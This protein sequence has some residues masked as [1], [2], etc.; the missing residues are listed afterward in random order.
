MINVMNKE[1]V[2]EFLT[3]LTKLTDK[4]GIEIG[5]CG[6]CGSPWI[7]NVNNNRGSFDNLEYDTNKSVYSVFSSDGYIYGMKE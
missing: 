6:C 3:E 5:G 2:V 4:Y 7:I 1:K